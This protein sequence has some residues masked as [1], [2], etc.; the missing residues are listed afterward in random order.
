MRYSIVFAV[1]VVISALA[2]PAQANGRAFPSDNCSEETPFM[3]F[4]AV[5]N[6][7]T[8]CATGQDIFQNALPNC[9]TNQVVAFDGT[10]FI[11]KD[12][13]TG[14]S[15]VPNCAA[16]QVLTRTDGTLSCVSTQSNT[17]AASGTWC[18]AATRSG[19][20]ACEIDAQ[21]Y[22]YKSV[23]TCNGQSVT[24]SCPAGYTRTNLSLL[25]TVGCGGDGNSPCYSYNCIRTCMKN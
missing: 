12:P 8:Y 17:T 10:H 25:V 1:T 5:A 23:T 16:G 18:G 7:N 24:S 9:S 22:E 3:A 19:P 20:L 4:T 2:G 15:D 14:G 11:C 21:W 6:S 13:D